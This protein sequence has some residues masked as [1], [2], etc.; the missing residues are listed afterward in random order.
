[1]HW[2]WKNCSVAWHDMHKGRSLTPTLILEAV[3]SK[4]LWIWYAFFGMPGSH[5]DI[6][7]LDHSPIFDSIV[8]GQIPPIIPHPTT[9]KEKLFAQRQEAYRKTVERAF[10]VLQS[11]WAITQGPST[12]GAALICPLVAV[13]M[14]SQTAAVT[15]FKVAIVLSG[16]CSVLPIGDPKEEN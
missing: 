1:M 10:G 3:A 4:D 15:L 16:L 11:K 13:R 8:I 7:V 6:N 9:V 5:N 14:V 12:N 2:E